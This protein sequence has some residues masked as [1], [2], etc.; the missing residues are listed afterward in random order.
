MAEEIIKEEIVPT[1]VVVNTDPEPKPKPKPNPYTKKVYENLLDAYGQEHLPTYEIFSEKI[2]DPK[3][4][5]AVHENLLDVYGTSNV[6]DFKAFNDSLNVIIPE[7]KN[8]GATGGNG[9]V[10]LESA[11]ASIPRTEAFD[12]NA[13]PI[14]LILQ[15]NDY[16]QKEVNDNVALDMS[17]MPVQS[18]TDYNTNKIK[19]ADDI[20]KHLDDQGFTKDF[21]ETLLRIKNLPNPA[22]RE[23]GGVYSNNDEVLNEYKQDPVAYTKRMHRNLWQENLAQ[24]FNDLANYWVKID[25]KENEANNLE[26]YSQIGHKFNYIASQIF[27][28]NTTLENRQY[29][30]QQASDAI[31]QYIR[32]PKEQKQALQDLAISTSGAFG[33]IEDY[34]NARLKPIGNLNEW[35]SM[36]LNYLDKVDKTTAEFYRKYLDQDPEKFTSEYEQSGYEQQRKELEETGLQLFIN[37]TNQ[38][39]KKLSDKAKQQGGQLDPEDI[40]T[41][42]DLYKRVSEATDRLNSLPDLYPYAKDQDTRELAKELT[43]NKNSLLGNFFK[44]LGYGFVNNVGGTVYNMAAYPFR[45]KEDVDRAALA[46]L[47]ISNYIADKTSVPREQQALVREMPKI[48]KDL[49]DKINKINSDSNLSK[50]EKT[51]QVDL[52]LQKNRTKWTPSSA[53]TSWNLN[54]TSVAASVLNTA[55]D[56]APFIALEVLTEGAATAIAPEVLAGSAVASFGRMFANV[57]LTSY[58]EELANAMREHNPNPEMHAW[59]NIFVNSLAFKAAGLGENVVKYVRG[60]ASKAGGMTAEVIGKMSDKEILNAYKNPNSTL[61]GFLNNAKNTLPKKALEGVKSA[62]GFESVM[63]GKDILEGKEITPEMLKQHALNALSFSIVNT[64]GGAG[65]EMATLESKNKKDLYNAALH[66]DEVLYELD[67]AKANGQMTEGAYNQAKQN[68]EAAAKVL[69]KT[70]MV[71]ENGKKLTEKQSIELMTLKIKDQLMQ[72][73]MKKELPE[74]LKEKMA[75]DW[76]KNQEKINDIYKGNFY[77]ETGKPFAGLEQRVEKAELEK[78]TPKIKIEEEVK[79]TEERLHLYEVKDKDGNI[80]TVTAEEYEKITGEKP[81]IASEEFNPEKLFT[82]ED[83]KRFNTLPGYNK[84]AE[85]NYVSLA[86]LDIN[87][88]TA[89]NAKAFAE[90]LAEVNGPYKPILI[91]ISRI[92]G[93]EKLPMEYT[94]D[95][96]QGVGKGAYYHGKNDR[97]PFDIFSSKRMAMSEQPYHNAYKTGTHELIHWVTM[98]SKLIDPASP[99]MKTL[100]NIYEYIKKSP[101]YEKDTYFGGRTYGLKDFQEFMAEMFTN[102]AFRKEIGDITVANKE[103]FLKGLN[104]EDYRFYDDSKDYNGFRNYIYNVFKE[105]IYKL[106]GKYK[107]PK[108][109]Y[110]KTLVENSVDLMAKTFFGEQKHNISKPGDVISRKL[111]AEKPE[112]IKPRNTTPASFVPTRTKEKVVT[113]EP[114]VTVESNKDGYKVIEGDESESLGDISKDIEKAGFGFIRK[115]TIKGDKKIFTLI[116]PEWNKNFTGKEYTSYSISFPKDTKVTMDDVDSYLRDV[117]FGR[118]RRPIEIEESRFIENKPIEE[119]KPSEVKPISEIKDFTLGYAPFREGKITDISQ[120]EKAFDNKA[121]KAWKKMANTFA[122]NIGL[123]IVSDN[124]TIGKYGATSTIGEASSVPTVRGT[125]EQI[126]L[127]ASLMGTLAPEGQHSVMTLEYDPNG[128][129]EEHRI[130][131]KDR[132]AAQEFLENSSKYGIEDLSLFP[133]SNTVMILD[134]G[135]VDHENLTKDYGEQIT[136]HQRLKV[137]QEFI[138]QDRYSG[139]LQKYGDSL[140]GHYPAAYRENINDAIQLAKERAGRFGSDYDQKSQQAQVEAKEATANYINNNKEALGLP[141]TEETTVKKVDT[142]FAK[143][144][145]D[146]YDALPV[147]DS[148]NP[149]VAAA[150]NKAVEEIDK[151]FQYLTKDLGIKVEFIKDDP[152]KNSDEM[153]E[154]VIN[155]KRLKVYQ[156]GEPHPFLGESSKDASGFTANEKLRAVHDYFGHFVNR[157]QFGKIGEEAAWVDHSKM[158]S[159][160]AQRAISTETRGQNSWVNFSGIN[161]AAI[162]KMKQGN[163]LIKEGKITEGNKLI[164]EGQAE[165]KFAE[166]KVA[167]LPKELTDWYKYTERGKAPETK[168]KIQEPI[169]EEGK[170]AKTPQ[171]IQI[172]KKALGEN[173]NFSKEFDVRGG[174]VVATDVLNNLNEAAKQNKVDLNTQIATE[175]SAMFNG[176]PEATEHNII[177]AGAHLLNIDKKIEAA[178]DAGNMSEVENLTQQREEVLS[179]LRTLGNKAGRNLGLFNLVFKDVDA[180]EIKVTRDHLKN[181]LKVS[182]VPETIFELENSNLT[183]DQKKTIRPYVE[184]IEK[185]KLQFDQLEKDVNSNIAKINDQEINAALDKARAEGKKEGFEEGLK[186]ASNEVKQKKSKQL[187][188]LA[189]KIRVSDEYDKLLKG[190]QIPSGGNKQFSV[191]NSG[192]KK[193]IA[194]VID[195]IAKSIESKK[196]LNE[197]LINAVKKVNNVD[198]EILIRDVKTLISK[199][200]LPSKSEAIDDISNLAKSEKTTIISKAMVDN[201][202]IKDIVNS[203]LGENLTNDQVLDAA[204]KDLKSILPNVTREDVADAYAE[205]NQFKKQTKA[206]LEDEINQRKADVKRLAIKEA[207]L[208]ALEAANDYHAEESTQKKKVVRSEYEA[209]LDEKI[210]AL[211]KEKSDAQKTQKT[212]K[213]PKTE[214]DRIN[215]INREIEYVKTT[216]FVYEQAIKNPKKASEALTAAR[217]ERAKTYAS[218]GLKLEKNA[219]SPILIERDYQEALSEI[220]RSS[221]SDEE[222]NDKR[223]ELKAQRDLD[224]LGTKQ[225]VVSSLSSDIKNIMDLS[226]DKAM[227]ALRETGHNE[228]TK[229][230]DV[231]N[232]LTE[233][234]DLLNPTGEKI[235]DQINKAYNKLNELLADEKTPKDSKDDIKQLIKDLQNN[236]QLVSDELAAKRLKKQWENEIRSAETDIASGNFTNIPATTYDFRRNDELVRLNKARENK[237]GQLNRLVADAKEKTRTGAEKALDISTKLLVSG[238]HTTAKVAEAATFKPFMDNL[239]DLTA[240][241]LA[242]A[243]TGAPYTSLYSVKKSLKTFAAFKNKEAATQYIEKLKNNRDVALENL[244]Y[245][246]EN[247]N[248]SDIKKAD[249]EFKKADLEYAVSTL[250]NSIESNSLNSFWQ[251]LKHGATD[252]DVQIGKST[253][254]NISDYRTLLGKTGYVL[255]G[256]IRMHSAMK[257]SLSAR[258]EMMKVFSSTLKDFQRKGM[259]LSPENISTAMVLAADAYEAGRLT[260]KTALSKIISRG[261]GS[262]KSTALRLLTKGLMPVSTIA[263]NLAKRGIDYSTLGAEGFVRLANETRKGMKLNEVEGKTYDGLMSAIK[264]GWKQI[265]LKERAYINGVIGRGLFGTGIMLATAYG[266]ANGSVKYGGTYED[267]KKRKIMG[268]DGQPLGPGEWEFFGKRLPKAGSLFVNHLPEFLA[269]S[270]MADNYQINQQGGSASDKFETTIDEIEARLPFQTLAGVLVP[271]RRAK[272]VVDRFTRFPLAAEVAG[273]IDEKAEFRDKKDLINRIRGNVGLGAFNPTKKQQEQIDI[274]WDRVKKVPPSAQTPEFKAKINAAIEK[275]KTIDFKELETK[276][277]MEEA[278]K[279]K[280]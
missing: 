19:I 248:E 246:H 152:Y 154:D 176:T 178:Q 61:K 234:R 101:K 35:Q 126:E 93:L 135:D 171:E 169:V 65:L 239:V 159:P 226:Y 117:H 266:L 193:I 20:E 275:M 24:N 51:N 21:R 181:I 150:Y 272:T 43:D 116:A 23:A 267:Q 91:A 242:S 80:K 215:E 98:S 68:V 32:D 199:S 245:A 111:P 145:K 114:K 261:K 105:F 185:A 247:G 59:G 238:I 71:D 76:L 263:V 47:G 156:G 228:A 16:K 26:K 78:K 7:K 25:S 10:P 89:P 142:E 189:S 192:Y 175:V 158:F 233:I 88:S 250:Y 217:E 17:G 207:R 125:K 206:K 132:K 179:V 13:N 170:P 121:F 96:I 146:A 53:E 165:F 2:K 274:I 218:L 1:E 107:D 221:L 172:S 37:T 67:K 219:K 257:S 212:I 256:W 29:N 229:Y 28:N 144:I 56:L 244:Q 277:A 166:Q 131:F 280:K 133:E 174:D 33:T 103:E 14:D 95:L 118:E 268:T 77:E 157:N 251:Y 79:P 86:D 69:E 220:D 58:Q 148:K 115:E 208:K 97:L 204:T 191:D 122:E 200:Q 164:A 62:A 182:E 240:G 253:K 92:P 141:E 5:Y 258:P 4:R 31:K 72:D 223:E 213:S 243:I 34:T 83:I 236:N 27:D 8:L 140:G 260:N 127:F 90:K 139:L 187:K 163:D 41:Y 255:D 254:K 60:A 279:N 46:N 120:G 54:A 168:V 6:P 205:R 196:S 106:I 3:Y 160:E 184:K 123:E 186:S 36:G 64:I 149:E 108:I 50:D 128:K 180:S 249:K 15:A 119:V 202:L 70:P 209:E 73:N 237:T 38:E 84:W 22:Y 39:L 177:T 110:D 230:F 44:K 40:D 222:K 235:D 104:K 273:V 211:L 143:K 49:Q 85:P 276:K 269:L 30:I 241:R 52:L 100:F 94:K 231:K 214:Q 45:S 201:G 9:S 113:F 252:Y 12:K 225:S 259:E 262:E 210:K 109:D 271:G 147:D 124:N 265:P 137:N 129:T 66:K 11:L 155:N 136:G 190:I 173:Y 270:L 42:N 87:E 112:P 224:L 203:Y 151:Q 55:A 102:E 232:K 81:P 57:A 198:K 130:T 134:N 138:T 278:Q 188:D 216:K 167:L 195:D 183:A 197:A 74:K 153:F 227:D 264:D 63:I 99:E 18:S 48:D 75:K 194:D 162:E 82:P 161:D